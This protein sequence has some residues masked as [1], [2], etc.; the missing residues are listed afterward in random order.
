[1]WILRLT[2]FSST[3]SKTNPLRSIAWQALPKYPLTPIQCN[4]RRMV[5]GQKKSKKSKT[6]AREGKDN[7]A[8]RCGK[9]GDIAKAEEQKEAIK[10]S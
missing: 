3:F 8:V 9:C 6:V 4:K 10:S 1:M 7:I 2:D 5:A